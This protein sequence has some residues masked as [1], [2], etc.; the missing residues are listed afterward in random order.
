[1]LESASRWLLALILSSCAVAAAQDAGRDALYGCLEQFE[2]EAQGSVPRFAEIQQRCPDLKAALDASP[3]AAWLPEEWWGAHLSINSLADLHQQIDRESAQH[4]PKG[5]DTS[6][7]AAALAS[8]GTDVSAKVS[9]WDRVREWLRS[10]LQTGQDGES[11]WFFRWIDELARYDT[12]LRIAAYSLFALIVLAAAFIVVNELRAAGVF[13]RR[14]RTGAMPRDGT[15]LGARGRVLT[16]DDLDRVDPLERPALLV[17]L[18]V[19]ALARSRD[20]VADTG[21]THRELISRLPLGSEPQ[22]GAFSHLIRCAERVRYAASPPSRADLDAAIAS[23]RSLL[24]SIAPR[25]AP[26]A[27]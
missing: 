3:H 16:L 26:A 23:G 14:A 25:G 20:R 21:A 5:I 10:R 12:A 27:A 1:L 4:A 17:A 24:E 13:G 7:V 18:V 6:G 22:R 8:L 2:D 9:W 19:N 15:G 11:S